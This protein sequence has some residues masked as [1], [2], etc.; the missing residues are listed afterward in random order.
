MDEAS[1]SEIGR[2]LEPHRE[3]LRR[4]VALRLDRRLAA[5]LDV[6]WNGRG[7]PD[8]SS[9]MASPSRIASRSGNARTW[10]T[11]S[12]NRAVTSSRLRV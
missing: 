12:G 3:R 4:T 5:R 9:S 11:T 10:A 6:S 7:R 8:S 2:L 1:L